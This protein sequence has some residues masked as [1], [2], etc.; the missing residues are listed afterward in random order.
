MCACS[1][2]EKGPIFQAYRADGGLEVGAVQAAAVG[3]D[4]RADVGGPLRAG[5]RPHLRCRLCCIVSAV[6]LPSH[7]QTD[8]KFPCRTTRSDDQH[9]QFVL[10]AILEVLWNWW[11][12]IEWCSKIATCR[13]TCCPCAPHSARTES[14]TPLLLA[15]PVGASGWPLPTPFGLNA[16]AADA[17][18]CAGR[19]AAVM[20][21][22]VL[23]TASPPGS[24]VPR[25]GAAA[26]QAAA[27]R[28]QALRSCAD[29]FSNNSLSCV[30]TKASPA[31]RRSTPCSS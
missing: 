13:W 24:T 14:A 31:C 12:C 23:A 27:A 6:A 22:P 2:C 7:R 1:M 9:G 8:T 21:P 5:I 28:S 4:V 3:S 25:I 17:I 20:L 10:L 16:S 19:S 11:G 26:A 29:V 15:L 30:S 18:C